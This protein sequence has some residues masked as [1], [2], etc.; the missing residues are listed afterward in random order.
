MPLRTKPTRASKAVE[1]HVFTAEASTLKG[2]ASLFYG[3][4]I[5]YIPQ[6]RRCRVC[7]LQYG[8]L[9]RGTRELKQTRYEVRQDC[10]NRAQLYTQ[11]AVFSEEGDSR[12]L[13]WFCQ[14]P[15]ATR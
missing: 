12:A 2:E 1:S 10:V 5:I 13:L 14:L 15:H 3:L 6:K 11:E 8:N 9:T 4:T 7:I